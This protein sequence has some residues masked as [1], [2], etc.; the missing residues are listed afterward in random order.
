[1][2][3]AIQMQCIYNATVVKNESLQSNYRAAGV[4]VR[5][6]RKTRCK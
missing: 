1:M 5:E 6:K 4:V 2:T 3:E